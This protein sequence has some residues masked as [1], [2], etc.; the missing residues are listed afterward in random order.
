MLRRPI[1]ATQ[2]DEQAQGSG[3]HGQARAGERPPHRAVT[4]RLIT[5]HTEQQRAQRTGELRLSL[6]YRL[7]ARSAQSLNTYYGEEASWRF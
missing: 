2:R 3:E 5:E 6:P 7:G 1:I 4:A